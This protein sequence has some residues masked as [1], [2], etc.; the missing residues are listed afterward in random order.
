MTYNVTIDRHAG[1]VLPIPA[2]SYPHALTI[3]AALFEEVEIQVARMRAEREADAAR[4][5]TKLF[6]TP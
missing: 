2:N 3:A 1:A 4:E 6:G 5:R